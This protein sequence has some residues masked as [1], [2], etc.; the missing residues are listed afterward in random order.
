[1]KRKPVLFILLVAGVVAAQSCKSLFKSDYAE[2][3]AADLT[4]FVEARFP[5]MYK[6]QLAQSEMIRKQF[7]DEF[8]KSFA[9]AQAAEDAGL[10]KSDEFKRRLEFGVEQL[11]A[12]KYTERNPDV[13][14]SKEEWEAYYAAHKDQFD[15]HLK[16]ITANSEQP[17]TDEQKE[18]QRELWSQTKA[19]A[20]KAR[21]AR[22]DKEPGFAVLVKFGKADLL[23]SLYARSLEAKHKLTDDEKKKYLAEHP[24]ADPDKQKEKAQGLLERVKKGENFE[25]IAGEFSDDPSNKAKGGDLGWFDKGK[26]DPAFEAAAFALQKGQTSNELVKS[27]F[28]Y[29]I[30]RV[31]DRRN[32]PPKAAASPAPQVPG[33]TPERSQEPKEQIHARHILI[34]T[35]E[36][37]QFE[38]RLIRDKVKRDLEDAT[39]KYKVVAPTDFIVKVA[40]LDPHL[41]PGAGGGQGGSMRE[42]NP[43][44]NK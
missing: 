27:R 32:A 29:H 30:I 43:G 37:E 17:I 34:D 7:I 25:K 44:E 22:L 28:G 36:S 21:Q 38:S 18:R 4:A 11:L 12:T 5:E 35:V 24:S 10:H 3:K 1:V 42:I 20:E 6:R 19:R 16:F 9:F 41:I 39:L 26:M 8:K 2:L 40:G 14:I 15:A 23:A 31:D 33:Q 13:V